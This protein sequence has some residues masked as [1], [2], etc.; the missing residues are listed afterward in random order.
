MHKPEQDAHMPVSSMCM[1][2]LAISDA[3]GR[4]QWSMLI[5]SRQCQLSGAANVIS[6][7]GAPSNGTVLGTKRVNKISVEP[8]TRGLLCIY[9]QDMIKDLLQTARNGCMD[10][11][12]RGFIIGGRSFPPGC[13]RCSFRGSATRGTLCSIRAPTREWPDIPT[14][15]IPTSEDVWATFHEAVSR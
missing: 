7:A 6:S 10:L 12:P 4:P 5:S 11:L 13:I 9:K 1:T 2:D 15:W 8:H 3:Y 14:S